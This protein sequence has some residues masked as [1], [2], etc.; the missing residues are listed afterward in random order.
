MNVWDANLLKA[1]P[2]TSK[3]N[4]LFLGQICG[5]KPLCRITCYVTVFS[6]VSAPM[7]VNVY[8]YY[9]FISLEPKIIVTSFNNYCFYLFY[10]FMGTVRSE[11]MIPPVMV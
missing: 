11:S 9:F 3:S 7:Y 1:Y 5:S 2:D 4:Y 8:Q 6:I 10:F